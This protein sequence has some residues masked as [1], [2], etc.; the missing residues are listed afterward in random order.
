MSPKI[1]APRW[2]VRAVEERARGFLERGRLVFLSG[3]RFFGKSALLG[4]LGVSVAP[5]S[6]R[7][8]ARLYE[9]GGAEL[10]SVG[11]AVR[12]AAR[13]G[14]S[15]RPVVL[16]VT[17]GQAMS[18]FESGEDGARARGEVLGQLLGAFDEPE[19]RAHVR[20][21]VTSHI[22][23]VELGSEAYWAMRLPECT[24]GDL[25]AEGTRAFGRLWGVD[26]AHG[27]LEALRDRVGGH[28]YLTKLL[29][30]AVEQGS[31]LERAICT[32]SD[33][34]GPL[35]PFFRAAWEWLQ[36]PELLRAAKEAVELEQRPANRATFALEVGGI[37]RPGSPP[38]PY[39]AVADW[40][41]RL[42]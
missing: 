30:A 25:S 13:R 5:V 2:L 22:P 24:I 10:A 12:H 41:G 35:A 39:G 37:V 31:S 29:F 1:N 20:L 33:D 36:E 21:V 38:V 6:L 11:E 42:R 3:P 9:L 28:P 8:P 4:R 17:D 27:E 26:F 19:V 14:S 15:E 40:I 16:H 32:S 34:D 7:D 18:P 23:F